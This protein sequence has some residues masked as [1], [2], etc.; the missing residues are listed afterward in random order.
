MS[1]LT[2]FNDCNTPGLAS[3]KVFRMNMIF[4]HSN[5]LGVYKSKVTDALTCWGHGCAVCFECRTFKCY[6]CKEDI[7]ECNCGPGNIRLQPELMHLH[8]DAYIKYIR[9]NYEL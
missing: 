4:Q 3:A 7:W 1:N 6:A 2:V 8:P 5:R 9:D